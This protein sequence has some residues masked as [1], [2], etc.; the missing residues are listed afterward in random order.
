[1]SRDINY[2]ILKGSMEDIEEFL[3]DE[4]LP[5]GPKIQKMKKKKKF[6][7]GTSPKDVKK[8]IKTVIRETEKE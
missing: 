2:N 1:M 4:E 7:D 3:D 5:A 8:K 6:D